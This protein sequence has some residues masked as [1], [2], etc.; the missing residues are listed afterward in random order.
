MCYLGYDDIKTVSPT[1]EKGVYI[2]NNERVQ[3]GQ[4]FDGRTRR[5][6]EV[7]FFEF[8]SLGALV[9]E[10]EVNLSRQMSTDR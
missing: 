5:K 7:F 2:L 8:T 6:L 1:I 10:D 3:V 4:F 9:S